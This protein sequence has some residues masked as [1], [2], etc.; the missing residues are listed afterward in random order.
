MNRYYDGEIKKEKYGHTN[1]QFIKIPVDLF[2]KTEDKIK[3]VSY[4]MWMYCDQN[5]IM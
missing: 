1:I 3:K 2:S 5:I 4:S